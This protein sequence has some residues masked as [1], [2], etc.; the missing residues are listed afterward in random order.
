MLTEILQP[1]PLLEPFVKYYKCIPANINGR[2][3]AVPSN[4]ME[5]YFNYTPIH[6]YVKGKYDL[7]NPKV[8]MT[9]LHDL[10]QEIYSEMSD[11]GRLASFVVVFQPTG[12]S[13]LFRIKPSDFMNYILLP[14]FRFKRQLQDLWGRMELMDTADQMKKAVEKLLIEF[15]KKTIV[16]NQIINSI[17][18]FASKNGGM[19]VVKDLCEIFNLTTR[20]LQRMLKDETGMSP[21]ELLNIY[22]INYALDLLSSKNDSSLAAVSQMCGFYD[23][24][25]FIREVKSR[26]GF[27]PGQLAADPE[28][29]TKKVDSRRFIKA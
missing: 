8:C 5:L 14:E 9:G 24:A 29:T 21:K 20:K 7:V 15:I 3:K 11:A 1:S 13:N 16:K 10:D 17:F 28:K 4:E 27:T 6:V 2:F 26:I 18:A 25:H 19:L 12:I 22:R 23:Q